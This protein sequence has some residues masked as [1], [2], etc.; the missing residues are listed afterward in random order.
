MAEGTSGKLVMYSQEF[1]PTCVKARRVMT[2][3][4]IE[5]DE[6]LLDDRE[7]WQDEVLLKTKQVTVPVFLHPDGRWEVGFRGERG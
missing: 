1:C 5:F 3:E 7:D 6:R 2:E 4:G